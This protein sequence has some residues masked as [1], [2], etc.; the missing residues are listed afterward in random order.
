MI[1]SVLLCQKCFILMAEFCERKHLKLLD[2]LGVMIS[3]VQTDGL[4]A[5]KNATM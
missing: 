2:T 4:I 1:G 3:R 5:A